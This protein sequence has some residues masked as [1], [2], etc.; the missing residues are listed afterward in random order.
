MTKYGRLS[1]LLVALL[2]PVPAAAQAPPDTWKF[3]ISPY[4]MGAAMSGT[5]TVRGIDVETDLSADDI[6]SNL[7]FGIM[8]IMTAR[9]GNWGIGGD[10]IWMALGTSTSQPPATVDFNQGAFSFYGLRRL[11]DAAEVTFG[12]RVNVLQGSL[13]LDGPLGAAGDQDKVWVDPLVGL[14]LRTPGDR[15]VEF[16]VY[17]EI[18]GFGLGS[19]FAWQVFPTVSF[20][21]GAHFLMDVGY[22]WID[23]DYQAGDGNDRFGYNV[24]TQGP[25]LGFTFRF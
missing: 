5:T 1:A 8:G 23:M 12:M 2:L 17:S 18:G 20:R 9:K 10:A 16:K 22:R 24:L 25:V 3:T 11:N 21:F 15:P 4:L 6:F 14:L 7:E 13:K 19:D